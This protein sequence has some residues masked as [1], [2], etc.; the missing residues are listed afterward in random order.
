M[1][2]ESDKILDAVQEAFTTG[3]KADVP[4]VVSHLKCNLTEN[5]GRSQEVV[6][7]FE[8]AV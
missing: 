2:T 7:T 3:Q 5:W 8:E 4:V 6:A 1:R